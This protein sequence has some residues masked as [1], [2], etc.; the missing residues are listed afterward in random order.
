MV[1]IEI[2][3]QYNSMLDYF[4]IFSLTSH[5]IHIFLLM[6]MSHDY[7]ESTLSDGDKDIYNKGAN[8]LFIQ[9]YNLDQHNHQEKYNFFTQF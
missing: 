7:H 1:N 3:Q 8:T 2:L 4:H 6:M 9:N 5:K